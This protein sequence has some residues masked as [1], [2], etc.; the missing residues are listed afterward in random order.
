M[1]AVVLCA[2]LA[3]FAL[4]STVGAQSVRLTEA[5]ALARF[6]PE[7]PRVRALRSDIEVAK[8]DVMA[9]NRWPNPRLTYDRE[10][11]AGVREDMFMVSQVLPVTGR[12]G[13]AVDAANA[14]VGATG[15]RVDEALRRARAD[16][17]IA[18]AQLVAAQARELEMTAAAA[19]IRDLA[20]ILAR[21]EAAGDTAGF[22]RLRAEREGLELDAD[23]AAAATE[24]AQAQARLAGY[25][26]GVVDPLQLVAADESAVRTDVPPLETLL[27]RADT[28]RGDLLA[29]QKDLDAARLSLKAAERG[30]VPEPEVVV[31]T[32]SSTLPGADR[33]GVLSLQASLPL[34]DRNAP[35]RAVALAR[36]SQASARA[37]ALRRI[38]R[39][40][41]AALRAA[42]VERRETAERYRLG[43]LA[44]TDE[45]E[46]IAQVS[47][48]AGERGI[49]ELLDAFRTS[50]SARL[51]QA[52]LRAAVREAEIELEYVSGWEIR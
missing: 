21:R 7:S 14:V 27:E 17:R 24:R 3:A 31:G 41:I 45:L 10:S 26:A 13:F 47:Y 50:A 38:A 46:R 23:L 6:S 25:F 42:V 44:L 28:V 15:L 1:R 32:K 34:F 5:D 4:P 9:A 2:T 43:A 36:A 20:A 19:R 49:L 52:A 12:R 39:A 8:V 22:D 18:F 16:L 30:R 37:E 29:L 40:D 11:V 35:E 51:R 33:G 48:D